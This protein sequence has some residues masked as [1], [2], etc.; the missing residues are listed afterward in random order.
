MRATAAD[1]TAGGGRLA[2]GITA[3]V[4]AP[5]VLAFVGQAKA[6][7]IDS[8][9]AGKRSDPLLGLFWVTLAMACFA[10]LGAFAKYAGNNGVAPLQ[11][12]FFRNVF[13]LLFLL[14]LLGMRGASLVKTDQIGMY[15][16]RVG[17]A[18]ISMMAW[19]YSLMLIP[20]GELSAIGFLGPLFG[21]L[22]AV[23][24]LGEAVK[25]RRITA[26]AVGFLGAMV[27]LRPTSGGFGLGQALA[28]FSAMT[29]GIVGPLLKQM[30]AK[31][32]AD[33][34]VFLS[35]LMM[36][37]LSLIPALFVW[38]WP[39]LDLWP[40]LAAM[41]LCAVVGHISLLRGF[42]STDAS[43]VFTFEF[44]RLPFAVAVAWVAFGETTDVLT[45]VGA[46]I[47]FASAAYIT[48]REAQIKRSDG[49]VRVRDMAGADALL[50]TPLRMGR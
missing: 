7:L 35:T 28:L 26:L 29:A 9:A 3:S 48:R 39:P 13:C 38:V 34:I 49:L 6:R 16:I 31:D 14:P 45:W 50:M 24:F 4:L 17:L 25:A 37:P 19:F 20:F 32:D 41:G 1:N 11:I 5:T 33:R 30:T 42:A 43:L 18:F 15:G 8:G 46:L 23:L 27:M 21:T 22:T 36:T 2:S 47:I 12:V 44:S 40:Y 10:G